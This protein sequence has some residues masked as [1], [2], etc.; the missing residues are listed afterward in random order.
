MNKV[1]TKLDGIDK[2]FIVRT[3]PPEIVALAVPLVKAQFTIPTTTRLVLDDVNPGKK[4]VIC[5]PETGVVGVN[6][7]VPVVN[8]APA[9]FEES[10]I[11]K[12]VI[13]LPC[14]D[15]TVLVEE[16]IAGRKPVLVESIANPVELVV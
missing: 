7:I 16:T 1:E 9:K 4:I 2:P 3:P 11:A 12:L 6:E 8:V 15:G 10:A 14:V 13:V 5:P